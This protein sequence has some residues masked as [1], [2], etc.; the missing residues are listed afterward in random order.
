MYKLGDGPQ[1]RDFGC[2]LLLSKSSAYDIEDEHQWDMK[3]LSDLGYGE[4]GDRQLLVEILDF[5]TLL[6]DHCGNRSIYASSPYLNDLLNSTSLSV[7]HAALRVGQQLALRYQASVKRMGGHSSRSV[8]SAL[9]ANHYN[10]ELDRVHQLAQPFVKTPLVNFTAIP[11]SPSTPSASASK[12][13]EKAHQVSS[14]NSSTMFAN[15]LVAIATAE[16]VGEERWHGWGDIRVTYYPSTS[17]AVPTADHSIQSQ[18]QPAAPST[19]TPLRRSTSSHQSR[20]PRSERTTGRGVDDNTPVTPARQQNPAME[21]NPSSNQRHFEILQS[22]LISSSIYDLMS[23]CPQDMPKESRY[24]LFSRLRI[25]KALLDSPETRQQALG[26]RLTAILNLAHIQPE[27]VFVDVALRQDNDEPRRYQLVYQLVELIHPPTAE[28][29]IPLWLQNI[30]VQLLEGIST[31]SSK[32]QDV[33]SALNA[34]VNHGVLLYIIRKT[35]ADI[36]ASETATDQMTTEDHWRNH[37]FSLALHMVVGNRS[38]IE[39]VSA[40]LMDVLVEMLNIRSQLADRNY[41]MVIAFLD[42]VVYNT[43]DA[44]QV[45]VNAKGLDSICQLLVDAVST[46]KALTG[47]GKGT[48]V[49]LRSTVVDYEIP[50]HQQQTLKWLLKFIHHT[51]TNSYSYGGNTDRLLRNLVDNSQFLASL[52]AILETMREHGS[53]VWTNAVMVLSDLINHDPTSF[54]ALLE[55]GLIRSFLEAVTCRPIPLEVSKPVDSVSSSDAGAVVNIDSK[56]SLESRDSVLG[57][58]D[59]TQPPPNQDESTTLGKHPVAA[60]ILAS[61]DA[62]QIIPTI[63]NSISLNTTGMK[64]VV[65]SKVL[66]DFFEIF[67]SPAHVHCMETNNPEVA[68]NIGTAFDELARH[69]PQLRTT[70]ASA[71]LGMVAAVVRFGREKAATDGWGAKLL[72]STGESDL[73]KGKGK[74]KSKAPATLASQDTVMADADDIP[75]TEFGSHSSPQASTSASYTEITPYINAVST[76]LQNYMG[77]SNLLSMFVEKGGTEFVLDL[78]ELPSLPFDFT[79]SYA[80]RTLQHVVSH[81]VEHSP[82][83]GLPSLLQRTRAAVDALAPLTTKPVS[84]PFFAPFIQATDAGLALD[85][86]ERIDVATNVLKALL[87]TQSLLKTL[88]NCFPY[89]NSRQNG[90]TLHPVNVFDYYIQLI[91]SLGPLLR[92][93][94]A[95][96]MDIANLVPK[97]WSRKGNLS[98]D[99]LDDASVAVQ[100]AP[101]GDEGHLQDALP[102]DLSKSGLENSSRPKKPSQQELSSAPYQNFT[103]IKG[104]VH[105]FMPTT[106]PFFHQ[107]GKALFTKRRSTAWTKYQHQRISEA[108][109]HAALDHLSPGEDASLVDYQHWIVMLHT[110]HEMIVDHTRHTD[111]SAG[112]VIIPVLVAFKENGGLACLNTM[113]RVFTA[114]ISNN[115][116]SSTEL[117]KPRMAVLGLKK[118]LELYVIIVNGRSINDSLVHSELPSRHEDRQQSSQIG[119]QLVVELRMAILPDLLHIWES[120]VIEKVPTSL[121]SKIIVILKTIVGADNEG[122]AQKRASPTPMPAFFDHTAVPFDW[123]SVHAFIRPLLAEKTY[124]EDLIVE[125]IYRSHGVK[126]TAVEYCRAHTAGVAGPR[127]PIPHIDAFPA[128]SVRP[129]RE[130]SAPRVEIPMEADVMAVDPASDLDQM[131]DHIG[132]DSPEGSGDDETTTSPDSTSHD[133]S[134]PASGPPVESEQVA[135]GEPDSAPA[136]ARPSVTKED[137]DDERKKLQ[138]DLVDRCLDI[139]RAHPDAVSDVS[140]LILATALKTPSDDSRRE[141]AETLAN[142]LMSFAMDDE[143]KEASATSI[144]SYA[145][146]LSMLLHESEPFFRCSTT[147]LKD[148]IGEYLSFLQVPP[149]TASEDLPPWIPYVLLIFEIALKHDEQVVGATFK[150][151]TSEDD[152][153]G[154]LVLQVKDTIVQ[155]AHRSA[156]LEAIL[157]ILPR[158]GRNESLAVAVLRILVILTRDRAMAKIVGEKKNMQRLFVMTKQLCGFGSSRFRDTN[159]TTNVLGILRHI[160]EDDEVIRQIMRAE[161]RSYF[162]VPQRAASR[163]G[164]LNTYH[165][166]LSHLALRSPAIFVEI[167]N[168]MVYMAS[169]FLPS[170]ADSIVRGHSATL[171]LRETKRVEVSRAKPKDDSVEPAVQATEGLHLNDIRPSTEAQGSA[172]EDAPKSLSQDQKRPIVE[173]PDGVVHF[174]LEQLLNYQ[175]VDDAEATSTK[176]PKTAEEKSSGDSPTGSVIPDAAAEDKDKKPPKVQFKGEE[177]PIFIY[178]CFLL[179]CLTELVQSYTRAKME[180]INFKRGAVLQSNTPVKPRSSVLNY[181]LH[182][183]LWEPQHADGLASKKKAATSEHARQ[184]LIALVSK[185]SETV[186]DRHLDR[187]DFDD[188]ADLLFT[189]KFVLDTILR[190]YKDASTGPDTFDVRYSKMLSLAALMQSM[191]G[192]KESKDP[193]T[194]RVAES[195]GSRSHNQIKRLMYEKGYLTTLT[196]SIADI[197]VTFP[198]VKRTIKYIL[199]VLRVLTSTAVALSRSNILGTSSRDVIDDDVASTSSISSLEDDREETPDLYRNSALGILEPGDRSESEEDDGMMP[200]GVFIDIADSHSRRGNGL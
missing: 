10:I 138:V 168:E 139:I 137:L 156:L 136:S 68:R 135:A 63:I 74:A 17:E 200:Q 118:L 100:P 143:M 8:S 151:P 184:L 145:H 37:L 29:S 164:D 162:E 188:D 23:R 61:Q 46:A 127:H 84:E 14:K 163:H 142:A 85:S 93:V 195:S 113:L 183:L 179:H 128:G 152:A 58:T 109:T 191:V 52:N 39:M 45:F 144:A 67:V 196:A 65:S 185:T 103:N 101:A 190:A 15:D 77:N 102:S 79:E 146:L 24:E 124:P 165:R 166:Q 114:E 72:G 69:H 96:D 174:L 123:P 80:A 1:S 12:G 197:D 99:H 76:F 95:E 57:D 26:V 126:D 27:S 6:L 192:D 132:E 98:P 35:V 160:V 154:P 53:V 60:G 171:M 4:D 107:I 94:L 176:E 38:G 194:R 89:S 134:A 91:R 92:V 110:L 66:E 106:F 71:V 90:N 11:Y 108:L 43:T 81:L 120:E 44:F 173:N 189:R 19:P 3:K 82:I 20:S 116:L 75:N 182:D 59:Q 83:L 161:I 121:V 112:H 86:A 70:I 158:V 5:S 88:S 51:M 54:A 49:E 133:A 119:N 178:R 187:W 111:R 117:T 36:K 42:G 169:P 141:V 16:K 130:D 87:N 40:G 147:T 55:S 105:T 9:L 21:D 32:F 34:N 28:A 115:G 181:L 47:L 155:S 129:V 41:A 153:V 104:L 150:M 157:E 31:F 198:G 167:T 30:A 122:H 180:F 78:C 140:D 170:S 33:V 50:F 148:N 64:M 18:H 97:H 172:T 199:R 175:K 48:P 7:V 22:S 193:I 186:F 13:K 56:K 159:I 2:E 131:L 177:H 62:I 149:S 125:G 73:K 25:A